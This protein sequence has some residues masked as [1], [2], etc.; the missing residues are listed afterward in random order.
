MPPSKRFGTKVPYPPKSEQKSP[1]IPIVPSVVSTQVPPIMQQTP[2]LGLTRDGPLSPHSSI[3]SAHVSPVSSV[4]PEVPFESIL[5][6]VPPKVE[7]FRMIEVLDAQ[8]AESVVLQSEKKRVF[9]STD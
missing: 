4:E 8:F 7:L 9:N 6:L 3:P 5:Q 2:S 1:M